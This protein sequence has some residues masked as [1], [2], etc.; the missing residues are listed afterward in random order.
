LTETAIQYVL[1]HYSHI[2][3][4]DMLENFCDLI[5]QVLQ[6]LSVC[7]LNDDSLNELLTSV[8]DLAEAIKA[9]IETRYMPKPGRSE[10]NISQNQ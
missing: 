5:E 1:L 3:D 2:D 7:V 6:Y 9:D 8:K 4:K 10:V